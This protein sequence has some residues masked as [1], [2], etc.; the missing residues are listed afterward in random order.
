GIPAA[1]GRGAAVLI[2]GLAAAAGLGVWQL[3]FLLRQLGG[4]DW[5]TLASSAG[6]TFVRVM[7]AVALATAW[8]LPAG[9][10]IGRSPRLAQLMQPVIQ[11]VAS[12]P[13]PMLFPLVVIALERVGLRLGVGAVV[14]MVLSGRWYVVFR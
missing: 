3:S 12:F 5:A 8:A 1:A 9:V 11:V 7:G 14:L 2:P 13:A 4:S 10:V 6:L